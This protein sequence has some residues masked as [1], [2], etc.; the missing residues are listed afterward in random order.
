MHGI[1][2]TDL[3]LSSLVSAHFG[4]SVPIQAVAVR[5][6]SDLAKTRT[7]LNACKVVALEKLSHPSESLWNMWS[8]TSVRLI[9]VAHGLMCDPPCGWKLWRWHI[10]HHEVCGVTNLEGKLG[11]C[12]HAK[13]PGCLTRSEIDLFRVC[14]KGKM[15][16]NQPRRDFRSVLKMAIEGSSARPPVKKARQAG[17]GVHVVGNEVLEV[18]P[19]L[20]ASLGLLK[21]SL[22]ASEIALLRV[23]TLF[24]GNVWVARHLTPSEPRPR[25]VESF[26]DP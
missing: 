11:V 16:S 18:K 6:R 9:L 13:T 1:L 3:R 20:V 8:C 7:A 15:K 5:S 17:A 10:L 24:G 19:G 4:S 14:P 12:Y 25:P 22:T 23:R 21:M 26:L 2:L